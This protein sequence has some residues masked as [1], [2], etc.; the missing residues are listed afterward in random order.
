M[1]YI[2]GECHTNLDDYDCSLVKVFGA[3][4]NKGDLVEVLYKGNVAQL[5]V[6]SI[7]HKCRNGSTPNPIPYIE[8]ELHKS[9][10]LL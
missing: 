3:I 9:R 1:N 5:E 8:I 4:P 10:H 6:V 2:Q 7:K